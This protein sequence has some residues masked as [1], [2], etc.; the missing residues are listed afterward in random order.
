MD[1]EAVK[2]QMKQFKAKAR[3]ARKEGKDAAAEAFRN[4]ARRLQRE[5]VATAPRQK[6]A[7]EG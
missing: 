5:L 2:T 4:R 1:R 3:K 6:K 7:A